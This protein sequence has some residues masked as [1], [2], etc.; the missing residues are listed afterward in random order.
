MKLLTS[1]DVRDCLKLHWQMPVEARLW[2]FDTTYCGISVQKFEDIVRQ[3]APIEAQFA[4]E[5][6]DCEDFA[7]VFSALVKLQVTGM[8]YPKGIAFGEVTVRHTIAKEVHTLNF[9]IDDKLRPHYYE[10]QGKLFVNGENFKP[11]YARI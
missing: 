1:R 6:F 2:L 9:L 11:F 7:H 10:P 4:A 3:L 5:L 8:H